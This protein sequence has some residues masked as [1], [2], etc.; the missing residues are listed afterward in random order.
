MRESEETR[1]KREFFNS[2]AGQWDE[3]S[4]PD[5]AK[6]ELMIRLLNI[7][8]GERALD[9]GTGTGVL[10]PLLRRFTH[11][12]AITAIDLAEK[13]LEAAKQKEGNTG[14]VFIAGDALEY[15]FEDESFDHIICYSVFPHFEDKR[16]AVRRFSELLKPGGLLSILHSDS[17]DAINHIHIHVRHQDIKEDNLPP[18]DT[19]MACM[20]DCG[21]REEIRIDNAVMYML[22]ARKRWH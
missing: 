11:A 3:R 5:A 12:P 17:R 13:M 18:A 22:C 20:Q 9:V 8:S 2:R 4:R 15:P 19:V 1:E 14:V 21:L 7:K 10:L 16:G 6:L